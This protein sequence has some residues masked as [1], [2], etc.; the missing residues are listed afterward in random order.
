MSN[1]SL[2]GFSEEE[3]Y[4]NL[5]TCVSLWPPHSPTGD[6]FSSSLLENSFHHF[7]ICSFFHLLVYCKIGIGM[8]KF[9]VKRRWQEKFKR[10]RNYIFIIF[11]YFLN[12][13]I[14]NLYTHF[15]IRI[16]NCFLCQ[17]M[18]ASNKLN[19]WVLYSAFLNHFIFFLQVKKLQ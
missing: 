18:F 3:K 8:G 10:S 11:F 9:C 1:G 6:V 2:T 15:K 16:Y 4:Q 13:S 7:I 12:L 5:F 17:Q 19:I 14:D